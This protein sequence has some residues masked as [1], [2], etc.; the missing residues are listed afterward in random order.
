MHGILNVI[1]VITFFPGILSNRL[2]SIWGGWEK[3]AFELDKIH[4][5]VWNPYSATFGKVPQAHLTAQGS[6]YNFFPLRFV[7]EES[8]CGVSW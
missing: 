7:M 4:V 1:T 8:W 3:D 6:K 2:P 5:A